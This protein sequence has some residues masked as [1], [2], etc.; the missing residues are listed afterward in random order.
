M[1][2]VQISSAFQTALGMLVTNA[3]ITR[4]F[5]SRELTPTD[6]HCGL[7]EGDISCLEGLISTQ[8]DRLLALAKLLTS[9]RRQKL[10]ASLPATVHILGSQL[11]DVWNEYLGCAAPPGAPSMRMEGAAFAA[12]ALRRLDRQSL[13]F[14]LVHYEVCF[15]DVA[16]RLFLHAIDAGVTN[17]PPASANDRVGL[18]RYARVQRF[19][20]AVDE[21]MA[22]FRRAGKIIRLTKGSPVYLVFHPVQVRAND[23]AVTKVSETM[24]TMLEGGNVVLRELLN[25]TP[26]AHQAAIR[27]VVNRLVALRILEVVG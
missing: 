23:I 13:E 2:P 11:E 19:D 8:K 16:N 3:A 20:W 18:S 9:R 4:R 24:N 10:I 22:Y 1:R 14:E 6:L 27:T 25:A 26:H 5:V 17:P 15:N 21:A 7:T 12:W